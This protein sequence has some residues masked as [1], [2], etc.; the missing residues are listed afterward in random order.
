[1]HARLIVSVDREGY[2]TSED[3]RRGVG[4]RLV[5]EGLV[6]EGGIFSSP[7]AEWFAIGGRWSGELTLARLEQGKVKVFW[8]R[9]RDQKLGWI[10]GISG[11]KSEK[12]QRAKALELFRQSFPD[13][14]GELPVW[15]GAYRRDLG[16]EDDAQ[17]LDEALLHFLESL[18][19][20]PEEVGLDALYEGECWVDL[21]DPWEELTSKDVGKKWVVVVDFYVPLRHLHMYTYRR[22][23]WAS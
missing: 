15:R 22:E 20:Y 3:A 19:W 21:D 5:A 11:S 12:L 16:Y 2:E 1:M 4:D 23:R 8:Q 6:G 14:E 10:S 9:F 17:V 7:P 13:F 18:K